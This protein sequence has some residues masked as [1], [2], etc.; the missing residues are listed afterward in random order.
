MRPSIPL[1]TLLLSVPLSWARA[2]SREMGF[3]QQGRGNGAM[4]MLQP[5]LEMAP[6]DPHLNTLAGL[7]MGVEGKYELALHYLERGNG[8]NLYPTAGVARRAEAL[9]ESGHGVEAAALHAE[10]LLQPNWTDN[11][12]VFALLAMVEDYRRAGASDQAWEAAYAALAIQPNEPRVYAFMA[13]LSLD[14]GQADEADA[15]LFL[16]RRHRDKTPPYRSYLVEARISLANEQPLLALEWLDRAK[17]QRFVVPATAA[18]TAMAML[19]LDHPE[20]A[21]RVLS[22][23]NMVDRED[24]SLLAALTRTHLALGQDAEAHRTWAFLQS[25]APGSP[26][27]PEYVP[28][29]SPIPE[30][31]K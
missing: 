4:R 21:L 1:L 3:I 17:A 18:L 29:L 26:M 23:P 13:E 24:P 20:E 6:L 16:A 25:V 28:G 5:K 19:Q 14:Q 8:T 31:P 7:A 30:L 15:F 27:F 11:K 9:R 12:A 22:R 2:P 10:R